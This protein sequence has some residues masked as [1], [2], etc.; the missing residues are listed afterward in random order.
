[1]WKQFLRCE[2]RFRRVEPPGSVSP[3]TIKFYLCLELAYMSAHTKEGGMP[4]WFNSPHFPVLNPTHSVVVVFHSRAY[5]SSWSK[6]I[7]LGWGPFPLITAPLSSSPLLPFQQ[8]LGVQTQVLWH[9]Y[10]QK[11]V[12]DKQIKKIRLFYQSGFHGADL[13]PVTKQVEQDSISQ[14]N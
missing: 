4:P 2:W 7:L 10:P 8:L 13:Q 11:F 3:L 5:L 14:P 12:L 9:C 6:E 1:M